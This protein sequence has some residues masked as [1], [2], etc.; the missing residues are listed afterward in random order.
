M[1]S[2]PVISP[3]TRP[4]TRLLANS[5][6]RCA[7]CVVPLILAFTWTAI[8]AEKST[9]AQDPVETIDVWPGNPP[10][11]NKVD[12]PEQILQGRPRPFYQLTNVSKPTISVFTPPKDQSTGAA[13]L[14][15]PGGGL[16]RLAFEHE[17]LEVAHWLTSRGIAAFVLKYRVPAP[18]NIGL[19]DA[20]RAMSIVRS[21]SAKWQVDPDTIGMMGFSAGGE[22]GAWMA[23]HFDDRQYEPIDSL[24]E[25]S[26]RPAFAAL[27]Y[28]GGLIS[29]RTRQLKEAIHSRIS[30]ETPPIFMVHAF[31]DSSQ[32]SLQLASALKNA[33][34]PTEL[35][36][37]QHGTHG[38]GARN[39]GL[40]VANWKTDFESWARANGFLD[41]SWQRH[42]VDDINKALT[43]GG[44]LPRLKQ[45]RP[46]ATIQ[47]AFGAQKRFVRTRMESERLAGFK[48]GAITEAAQ[49]RLGLSHPMSGV[50]F[51]SG[52]VESIA[53][54]QVLLQ[55][56]QP[57]VIETE[58]GFVVAVDIGYEV[59]TAK[60]AQEAVEKVLP[61]VELPSSYSGRTSTPLN[62]AE[63]IAVNVGANR[64]IT[65][66]PMDPADLDL[67]DLPI[68]LTRGS[69]V[70][71][72]ASS[73]E[74]KGDHW[75]NLH[76]LINQVVSQGYTIPAG[77]IIISG[78]IGKIHPAQPG[79]YVADYGSLGQIA[80]TLID[81]S[82]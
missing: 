59:L 12:G 47:D 61:I 52:R 17:G 20:Q 34:V 45:Y 16:Q 10:T 19:Q 30:E 48:G 40:G 13:V 3:S 54:L 70:L 37:Y 25:A 63:V 42:Y 33:R 58:L 28:P 62:S 80:F 29:Y 31:G 53:D 4:F 56:D 15:C 26:C 23:T 64:Y 43:D 50:L 67:S 65:G 71:H 7:Q 66:K 32:N 36:L 79:K 14:V 44:N 69:S 9:Q 21:R 77:S 46:N 55:S 6:S 27:I 11:K 72:Q 18:I 57:A 24:D 49:E 39:S 78:A 76:T 75:R 41:P 81:A 74:V 35:H 38:F 51:Q 8:L 2:S 68:S 22:I 5:T 73:S 82:N 1:N 60:Q